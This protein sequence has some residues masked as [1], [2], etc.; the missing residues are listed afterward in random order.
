MSLLQTLQVIAC[1]AFLL[2]VFFFQDIPYSMFWFAILF[3][4]NVCLLV[5]R[6]RNQTKSR[7][8]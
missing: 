5:I 7:R 8:F 6:K 4:L 3:I 1:L 2:F